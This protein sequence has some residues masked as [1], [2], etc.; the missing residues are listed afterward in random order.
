[1]SSLRKAGQSRKTTK[2]GKILCLLMSH[3][4]LHHRVCFLFSHATPPT[5]S[6]RR[7]HQESAAG[8]MGFS[9]ARHSSWVHSGCL[10]VAVRSRRMDTYSPKER[11]ALTGFQIATCC[12]LR[13]GVGIASTSYFFLRRNG[14]HSSAAV[15]VS[16]TFFFWY[17][18][19][20]L[21]CVFFRPY[22][23]S[24]ITWYTGLSFFRIFFFACFQGFLFGRWGCEP[25]GTVCM[26][27]RQ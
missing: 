3:F 20:I 15:R 25:V 21:I 10:A 23:Q 6:G 19:G 7:L 4:W 17:V 14:R 26:L 24:D 2:S 22:Y 16:A 18:V 12:S 13:G 5:H 9:R 27:T 11:V 8:G 1:M